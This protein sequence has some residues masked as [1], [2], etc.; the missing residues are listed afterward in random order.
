M[1][2]DQLHLAHTQQLARS[3]GIANA[4]SAV[5]DDRAARA[6]GNIDEHKSDSEKAKVEY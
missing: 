3:F 6:I 5:L 1:N 2:L 4:Q